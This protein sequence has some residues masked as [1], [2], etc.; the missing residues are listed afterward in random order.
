MRYTLHAVLVAASFMAPV[1]SSADPGGFR[2]EENLGASVNGLGLQNTLEASLRR[3]LFSD[4]RPL[5]AQN[6]VAAG[7]VHAVTPAYSRFAGYLEISP[8]SIADLRAGYETSSYF[9]TFGS[10]QSFSS[11]SEPFGDEVRRQGKS[12]A[13]SARATR[14][15]LSPTLKLR[16]GSLVAAASAD[17]E[18]WRSRAFGPFFYEPARDTLLRADHDR[19]IVTTAYLMKIRDLGR[20]GQMAFGLRHSLIYVFDA[21]QNKSERLGIAVSRQFGERR[22]G[23][24]APRVSGHVSYYVQ[25]P[26][27]RGQFS[28]ALGLGFDLFDRGAR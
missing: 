13:R 23:V 1:P 5:L 15:F 6:H 16:V 20:R 14:L 2:L 22:F 25:D 11:Y 12:N 3:S 18:W 4:H 28:A 10:I 27:R 21:P 17:L 24:R 26:S 7:V 8:L 9:G 19:A